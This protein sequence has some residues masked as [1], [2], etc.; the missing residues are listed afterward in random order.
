MKGRNNFTKTEIS[1]LESLII[2]RNKT[3]SSKQK[4]I[5]DKMRKIGF[6]G[7]DDWGIK[8]LQISD[9]QTLIKSK[10][11]KVID[12]SFASRI[13]I[14]SKIVST[15]NVKTTTK[16]SNAD[17]DENYVL[18]LCDKVLDSI[19]SRQHKFDFLLGDK[20]K[21][22]IAT[23][24]PVDSFYENLKLVIEYRERQHTECVTFFDKP[25][26][27]TISGVHRGEQRKIYDERR[28]QVLPKNKINLIEF[29]YSDFNY[30]KQKRIIKNSELDLEIIKMKL[31]NFLA[32]K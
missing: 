9:L 15:K 14:K 13:T 2:L 10:Q 19:S 32:N 18:D 3:E 31:N 24:L 8:N 27:K 26:R 29:S 12:E 25:N 17:K 23:K 30:D 21:N 5:R 6:Y 7:K 4:T 11:I 28:R 20:N 22:G 1:E 16:T